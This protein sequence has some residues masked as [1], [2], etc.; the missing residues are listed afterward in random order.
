M[1]T[2]EIRQA[3]TKL[4]Y[5]D[6][7]IMMLQ[8]IEFSNQSKTSIQ[9]LITDNTTAL[10]TRQNY[11]SIQARKLLL[12]IERLNYSDQLGLMIFLGDLYMDFVRDNILTARRKYSIPVQ[13]VIAS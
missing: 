11:L 5:E 10:N 8:I 12:Q 7:K 6:W 13:Y 1:K 3:I 9:Q 4:P 2:T